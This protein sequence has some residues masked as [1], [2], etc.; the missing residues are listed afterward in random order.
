MGELEEGDLDQDLRMAAQI[1]PEDSIFDK[2]D[3]DQLWTILIGG[4]I[5][6]C[7]LTFRYFQS[8]ANTGR[9]QD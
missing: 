7:P 9:P 2:A 1:L 4:P 5:T 3:R 8:A 6:Q